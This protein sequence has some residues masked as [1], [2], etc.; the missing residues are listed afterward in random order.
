MKSKL[1]FQLFLFLILI[2]SCQQNRDEKIKLT[3]QTEEYQLIADTI[4]NDIMIKAAENDEWA[5]YSLRKLDKLKLVNEIFDLVYSEELTPYEYFS[6]APLR[7]EEIEQLEKDPEFSRDKIAK[8]QF[9]EA[10][11][12]DP[13]GMKMTK[14]VHSIML[15]YEVYNNQGEIKG[16]KP[17]FKVFLK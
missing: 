15:A 13:I 2:S 7:I 9:V 8:V 10:W 4:I 5:E 3:N 6:E 1:S 11:Y 14:R 16:Y 12:F 17:A